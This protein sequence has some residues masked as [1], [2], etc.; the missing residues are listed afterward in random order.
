MIVLA[1]KNTDGKMVFN[2]SQD[3]VIRAGDCLIVIGGDN[4]LKKL[5]DLASPPV[6]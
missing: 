4:G 3:A 6:V 2:P 1:V 5:E